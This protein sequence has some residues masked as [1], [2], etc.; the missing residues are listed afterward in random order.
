M[1]LRKSLSLL[2]IFVMPISL[3]APVFAENNFD[4]TSGKCVTVYA[5]E[6]NGSET[7]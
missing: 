5:S 2:L 3:G 7:I 4:T 1:K 6:I